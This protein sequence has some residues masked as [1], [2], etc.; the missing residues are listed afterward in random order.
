MSEELFGKPKWARFEKTSKAPGRTVG[1]VESRGSRHELEFDEPEPHGTDEHASPVSAMLGSLV[2][3]QMSVLAQC[4][5]KARIEDYEMEAEAVID[6]RGTGEV[7]EEMPAKTAKRIEHI[8]IDLT[9]EVPEEFEGRANRCIEVYDTGCIVG[10][11]FRAG[12]DYT[13]NATLV[14]RD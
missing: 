10:Q 1:V 13:P 3:C 11:S 7:A 4:L 6:G 2:A 9:L 5:E 14:V 8:T 12:I